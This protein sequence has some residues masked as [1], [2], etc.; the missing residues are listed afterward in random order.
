M[1]LD[2]V[3]KILLLV[4][5]V[6]T[7]CQIRT[8][9]ELMNILRDGDFIILIK[10]ILYNL[11]INSNYFDIK[12]KWLSFYRTKYLIPQ[13]SYFIFFLISGCITYVLKYILNKISNSLGEKLIPTKKWSHRIRRIKVQRFNLMFF[14]LFYFS[15]M[16]IFGFVVLRHETYF[17]TEMGGQGK[18]SDYF[19]DYPEQKTSNLIH[20]YY[21]LNGGYLITSV[22][23]LLIS[24]KLPDF[25]ENF[26]QHLCA[27]ILVYFSY[28]QNFIRV[29]AIIML[30]HD[31]CEIFSSACRVFVDT[32]YKFITVTS[33]CIL[34]TSWGFLRL[35]I[36]VKR[37]I[38]PIHRNFDIFIKYLKVETCIWLIF[39]LLVILL[40][41]TYWL[42][43]MAKMFIHFI[44][45][46][47]TEDILTR[48]SEMEHIENKNKKR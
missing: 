28:S 22:Y 45:S 8:L 41:N 4:V 31:I 24:E 29:G 44:M 36:F 32:R 12:N 34:F 46:G 38:L 21:F 19:V 20:L 30:C 27:I 47:K 39:L 6:F 48:V 7:I 16:S 3:F 14:N 9:N 37:C 18:L 11:I 10:N 42:I 43:L 17:P 25:Y 1:K 2:T 26:L 40:M 5:I 13:V 15:L 23:S 35:Y 33:F